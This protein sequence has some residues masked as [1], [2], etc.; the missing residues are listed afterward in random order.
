MCKKNAFPR[1]EVVSDET[2]HFFARSSAHEP[3][4]TTDPRSVLN[5]TVMKE[6]KMLE[7]DLPESIYVRVYERRIDLMRAVI[8]GAAGTPYENGLFF[9]DIMFPS[10]YPKQPPLL[11]FH[12]FG[13]RLN[14]NL[15]CSGKVCLSLL[16]TWSGRKSEK[17][18][19]SRSTMLQ[20]LLS[21]QGLVLN[22]KPFFNEPGADAFRLFILERKSRAYNEN[23]FGLT[24]NISIHLLRKP[25]K[26]FETFVKN[27]FRER[28]R[29]ILG[30]C[31]RYENG[32]VGVGN[33]SRGGHSSTVEVSKELKEWMNS[34]FPRLVQAFRQNDP[35]LGLFIEQLESQRKQYENYSCGQKEQSEN[36]GGGILRKAF[37]RI[38]MALG[39]KKVERKKTSAVERKN[40]S[41]QRA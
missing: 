13:L 28:A 26:Y 31:V 16:N 40:R 20:V 38:K 35:S 25:P 7:Q 21:I 23:V 6:W 3:S 11:H 15:Y 41:L 19:P 24:C 29:V 8:I 34:S 37:E 39:W 14:P 32:S 10:E 9:F 30:L 12:S 22:E 2:D 4:I 36:N 18:D 17:W 5:K 27:H 33:H 1:F